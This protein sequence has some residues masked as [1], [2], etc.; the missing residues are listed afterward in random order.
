MP[1]GTWVADL[2]LGASRGSV[3]G[4]LNWIIGVA[5]LPASLLAGWLW[6]RY[7]PSAPFF[8]SAVLAL[9]AA[10]LLLWA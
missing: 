5:G 9:G 6:H 7:S 8:T 4:I 1:A 3:F 10:V 2:V